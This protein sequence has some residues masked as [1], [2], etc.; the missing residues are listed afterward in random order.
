MIKG[1]YDAKSRGVEVNIK[2]HCTA[3]IKAE[4]LVILHECMKNYP[5]ET[6]DVLA[7]FIQIFTKKAGKKHDA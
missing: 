6:L 4:L 3:Q 5:E 1:Q 2:A 7:D